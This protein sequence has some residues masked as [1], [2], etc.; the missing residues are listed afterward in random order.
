MLPLPDF[1][2]WLADRPH[3]SERPPVAAAYRFADEAFREVGEA[4]AA[5]PG[6]VRA[7][8][9]GLSGAG[10][11][12]W[13]FDVE[14]PGTPVEREILVF[15][16]IHAL[17][18]IS[19]EVAIDV[20]VEWIALPPPGVRLTVVPLLN[21]DGR[22]RVEEDLRAG[23][24][25]YRRGNQAKVDLNR[26]FEVNREAVAAWKALLPSRY[27]TS[28]APLSQPETRALDALA[29]DRRFDRAVSLHAFGGYL[30]HPW[31]GRWR[32]PPD[33]AE[34]HALGRQMEAAQAGHAYRTRQLARWGFF[35][36]AQGTEID[37]L[38]GRYGTSAWLIELTRSGIQPGRAGGG[39]FFRWYNPERSE[40]HRA[41]GVAAVRALALSP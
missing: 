20:L 10:Q 17:E 3:A 9:L 31:S 39:S 19:T 27:H 23:E 25:R 1:E 15:A 14:D 41:R 18:W 8:V 13:V 16:G 35:F 5:H 7:R 28:P 4:V 36:R 38:Y 11:P 29:A 26:D 21:P 34:M 30:Y 24:N 6:V 33:Y 22:A 37:H 40:S 12:I 2:D 32:R